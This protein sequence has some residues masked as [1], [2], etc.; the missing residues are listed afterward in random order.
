MTTHDRPIP[1]ARAS[2][3]P[4]AVVAA[5]TGVLSIPLLA[6]CLLGTVTGI[7]ALACGLISQGRQ[8]RAR[9]QGSELG[10]RGWARV[11]IATGSTALVLGV[12]ILTAIARSAVP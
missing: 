8:N 7:V 2:T 3:D 11:G 10:G 12:L 1:G 6:V 4:L 9:L 5:T